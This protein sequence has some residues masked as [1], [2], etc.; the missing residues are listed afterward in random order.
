LVL[1]RDQHQEKAFA[2]GIRQLH[3]MVVTDQVQWPDADKQ[4][5]ARWILLCLEET[6]LK[7][8][9]QDYID[10]R[11]LNGMVTL[12]VMCEGLSRSEEW[13]DDDFCKTIMD[14]VIAND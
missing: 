7:S 5:D 3:A 2:D 11:G 4:P 9:V 10:E 14:V 12:S 8:L 1:D 6:Q 13:L